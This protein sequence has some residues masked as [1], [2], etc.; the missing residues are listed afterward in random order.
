MLAHLHPALAAPMEIERAG[1][2]LL[3][4]AARLKALHGTGGELLAVAL[5]EFRFWIE[6][7]D[8]TRTTILDEVNHRL[9]PR[10]KVTWLGAQVHAAGD[11][12]RSLA[13]QEALRLHQIG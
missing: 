5:G 8:L 3:E 6:K 4:F 7:I 11:G 2:Q 12:W 10:G 9:G 1:Q 13:R